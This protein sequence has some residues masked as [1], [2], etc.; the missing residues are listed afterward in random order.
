MIKLDIGSGGKSDDSTFIS[1]DKYVPTADIMADMWDLPFKDGEVDVIFASHCLEH[2]NKYQ[3]FPTLKEWERILKVGGKLQI[4]V[5]DLI[6]SCAWF[7]RHPNSAYSMDI[8]FGNQKHEGEYHR[9]GF[10]P[11]L[12]TYY[13]DEIPGLE[14]Q[15]IDF[16]GMSLEDIDQDFNTGDY[17]EQRVINFEILR[18]DKK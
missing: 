8:I 14:V 12:M 13:L 1:V 9:T 7:I 4:L 5:P 17:I 10:T 3:V 2:V 15:K 16:L 11:E 6:W 18:V